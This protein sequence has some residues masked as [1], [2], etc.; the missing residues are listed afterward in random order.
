MSVIEAEDPI[1]ELQGAE[2]N[3]YAEN[4]TNRE[5]L[6]NGHFSPPDYSKH[7]GYSHGFG[8]EENDEKKVDEN[9]LNNNNNDNNMNDDVFDFKTIRGYDKYPNR[10]LD[11]KLPKWSLT[12]RPPSSNFSL[13]KYLI[14]NFKI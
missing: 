8:F 7:N 3:G 9:Y 2:N 5:L 11:W 1:D 14:L 4:G 10:Q 12:F 13:F 6:C